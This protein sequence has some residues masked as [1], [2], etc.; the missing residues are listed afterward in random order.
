[1]AT[2]QFWLDRLAHR[3]DLQRPE[4]AL[5][6]R[7]LEG[8]APLPEGA[9]GCRDAYKAFQKKARTN[10]AEL[11]I[12]AM[13]DRMIVAGFRVGD[14]NEDDDDVRRI[15]KANRL[16]IWS[17][18]VHRDMLG[19]R[20]GY[21][22][23][24]PGQREVEIVYE[25]PE[26]AITDH[27]PARPDRV[28]AAMKVYRDEVQGMDLAF[29]H[30]PGEVTPYARAT[31]VVKDGVPLPMLTVAG[32]WE[33]VGETGPTGLPEVPIIPFVN[34]GGM[35]E[36]ETHVDLLDRINW[37]ALQRLVITAIQAFK[38][39]ATKG[40]LPETDEQGKVIDYG[41][42]FKPGPGAL[43]HLPEGIE[44]QELGQAELS[45]ILESIKADVRDLGAVTRTPMSMLLPETANQS[46][47]G[48]SFAREGL[49]FKTEDRIARA[50]VSWSR[51][52]GLALALDRRM[53]EVPEVD[54]QWLPPERQS[55]AER[56]AALAQAGND[57]PW[58]TKM[59][60]ILQFEGDEV[61][62]MAAERAE[63]LM[64]TA[65]FVAPPPAAPAPAPAQPAIAEPE[66]ATDGG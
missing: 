33:Q 48:A 66:S 51:V 49:V 43:W 34:R 7:Y 35:G 63:D 53:D 65:S 2:P 15:W 57:V 11:V 5:L 21:V 28:R 61:D 29:V 24:Q 42:L 23:V 3:L 16:G 19:L 55:L 13:A 47:E 52:M 26:Q 38:Q 40:D 27:D 59:T 50:G 64:F 4:L 31:A 17:A 18:D 46:A 56:Y 8:D 60:R 30:T 37:V 32:G 14:S 9:E 58:R 39:R 62:R 1:M 54:T 6:R 12:D 25:R 45:G 36:F 22:C 41:E 44:L 20:A 10:F